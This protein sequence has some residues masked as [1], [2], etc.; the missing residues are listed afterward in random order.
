MVILSVISYVIALVQ[1]M[2]TTVTSSIDLCS[3]DLCSIDLCSIYLCTIDLSSIYLCSIDLCSIDLC[4]IDLCSIDL[5]SIDLCN[6]VE[7]GKRQLRV[8]GEWDPNVILV[9]RLAMVHH[10]RKDDFF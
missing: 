4:R 2:I 6:H 3:I 7:A 8:V 9:R 10:G 1:L 5:C